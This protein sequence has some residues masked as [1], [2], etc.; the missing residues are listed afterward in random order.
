M[1]ADDRIGID[2]GCVF[3]GKLTSVKLPQR[4]LIQVPG[5]RG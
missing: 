1:M 4:E 3:G 5:W 2:T